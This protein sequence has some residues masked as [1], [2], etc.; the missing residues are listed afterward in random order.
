MMKGFYDTYSWYTKQP[1]K[2]PEPTINDNS[3]KEKLQNVQNA[4]LIKVDPSQHMMKKRNN[5]KNFDT[6]AYLMEN[7][8]PITNSQYGNTMESKDDY[9][10]KTECF[11]LIKFEEVFGTLILKK[12]SMVFEP[13]HDIA[14]NGH[15]V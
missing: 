13:S 15:L 10:L 7:H 8:N 3:L 1:D 2:V 4:N 5:I 9:Y 6:S 14:K 11:Y 12:D